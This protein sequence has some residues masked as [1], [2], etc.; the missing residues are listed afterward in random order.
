M[1]Q[2]YV[3]VLE[4]QGLSEKESLIYL[5][6]L[7]LGSAPASTVARRT[8]IKRVTVYSVLKDLEGKQLAS[9]LEKKWVT[10]FQVVSPTKLLE[11]TKEKY[12]LLE[13]KLPELLAFTNVYNNKPKVA[14]FEWF[15]GVKEMYE[16]LLTSQEPLMSFLGMSVLDHELQEYLETDFVPRRVAKKIFAKVMVAQDQRSTDYKQKDKHFYKETRVVEHTPFTM[17]AEINLYGPGKV[18]IALFSSDEMSALVIHS[19]KLYDTLA[20]IFMVLREQSTPRSKSKKSW[21]I[22]V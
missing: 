18:W 13:E 20:N 5:T 2:E 4:Q 17:S 16:D 3:Q 10:Y 7:E 11:K 6:I 22:S 9:S 15:Q 1:Q 14:Y 21:G 12:A 19:Q 8:W